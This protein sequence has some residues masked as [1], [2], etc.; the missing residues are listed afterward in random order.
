V[1]Q[2]P[3]DPAELEAI[4]AAMREAAASPSRPAGKHPEEIAPLPLIVDDREA[5]SAR[6]A[7]MRI[8]GRWIKDATARL[9]SVL[10]AEVEVR[11]SGAE[12]TSG[13]AM[14]EGLAFSWQTS[15]AVEGRPA[16]ALLVASGPL[17]E[18][19]AGAMC[20][21]TIKEAGEAA[22]GE[23]EEVDR[24]PSPATIKIFQPLGEGLAAAL[25]TAWSEEQA[26]TVTRDPRPEQLDATRRALLEADVVVSLTMQVSGATS[27]R[28]RLL[29][30]P[31]TL[32]RPPPPIEAV[33][34]APGALEA[35]LA[36]VPV[37]V[38]VELGR[39][40]LT[41]R[42]FEKLAVGTVLTLPQFVDDPLPVECGGVIKAYGRP[43]VSRGVLA[44]QIERVFTQ[45]G[46]RA[47]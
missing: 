12:I 28:L 29:G 2:A 35:V 39:T 10:R 11:V 32:V 23:E 40:R 38:R 44:V 41:M 30:R 8:G 4:Q 15:L 25:A 1:S 9:R 42:E 47:A 6:P 24:P 43:V 18:S 5:E 20:G 21:A 19:A 3:L 26:T 7:A 27:G 14:R 37:E 34:A 13:E 46:K 31:A 16:A 33:A 45:R 17:L 22:G 36:R